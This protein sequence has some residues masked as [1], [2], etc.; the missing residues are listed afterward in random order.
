M[1]VHTDARQFMAR[2]V[3]YY[4]DLCFI[5]DPT[6]DEKGYPVP[7][8]L[9]QQNSLE[10]KSIGASETGQS[11]AISNYIEYPV[12]NVQDSTHRVRKQKRQ[13]EK[14]SDSTYSKRS[15]DDE[16]GMVSALQEMATAVSSLSTEKSDDNSVSIEV[17]IEAIQ[18]LPDM[19]EDLILDACDFLE[20]EKKAK[21]FLALE[22]KLRKKWLIRK[23]RSQA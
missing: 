13:L 15:K 19:D 7:Q 21:T 18:S 10:D 22:V 6:I 14:Y 20:D 23:L 4:K 11:P 8:D 5:C 12:S 17:V 3:P 9:D 2:P 1:Q 16:Q